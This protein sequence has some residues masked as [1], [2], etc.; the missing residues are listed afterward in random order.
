[1]KSD[2]GNAG[3]SRKLEAVCEEQLTPRKQEVGAPVFIDVRCIAATRA[4]GTTYEPIDP[5]LS[6]RSSKSYVQAAW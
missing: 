3:N 6:R 2:R 4:A 5:A 1:M